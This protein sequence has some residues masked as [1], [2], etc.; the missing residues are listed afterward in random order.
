MG[1]VFSMLAI[2]PDKCVGCRLCQLACSVAKTGEYDPSQSRVQQSSLPQDG[3]VGPVVCRH[4]LTPRCLE[5]CPVAAI[6]RDPRGGIV[7]VDSQ[8]C[9]GCG[10]CTLACQY[11]GIRYAPR[12]RKAIKCDFCDGAPECAKH[13]PTGALEVVHA[14]SSYEHLRAKEDLLSPGTSAC[15]GCV[16]ELGLRLTLKSLG[17]NTIL[18]IPPGCLGGVGVVGYGTTTGAAVPVFFPLL[19]NVASMLTG[20]KRHY[21]R[22][23]QEVNVV[24]YAGDGGT[25]D[26]GFQCLSGAAER[27]ENIIYICYDN[28]GYMN[29]GVQRSGTTPYKAWTTTTPVGE[30]GR[31][32][33]Q[34]GKDMPLIMAM[35]GVPYVATASL[36]FLDDYLAKLHKAMQVQQGLSYIHIFSP[37]PTGWRFPTEKTIEVSRLAVESNFFPLWEAENGRFRITHRTAFAQPVEAYLR[38][39]GKYRHLDRAEIAEIQEQVDERYHRLEALTTLADFHQAAR[40]GNL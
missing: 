6:R 17:P 33:K 31:G 16:A 9:V 27:G 26:A 7:A 35:H 5:I 25:A 14:G 13:C 1:N 39:V 32:K 18:A 3:S 34:R 22:I 19:D 30:V 4:C 28:E 12:E 15:L 37:C 38:S 11:G 40:F 23:G 21:Q 10:L 29:T 36:A 20:I 24:A 2:H 8:R